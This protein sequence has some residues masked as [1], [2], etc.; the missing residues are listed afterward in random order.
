MHTS[1]DDLTNGLGVSRQSIYDTY[2]DKNALFAAALKRYLDRGLDMMGRKLADPAPIREV[3][4][5]LFEAML[6]GNCSKGTPGC[7]MVNSMVEMAPHNP[8]VRAL[9]HAHAR[10]TEGLFASRLGIAQRKG[11]I[12]KT[13]DTVALARFFYTTILGLSVSSRALGNRES[14]ADTARVAL[15]ILD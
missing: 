5:G 3:L 7:L 13:K 9:A 15:Q 2:G 12:S 8:E 4:G 10:E 11:E 6:A 14:L 1:F